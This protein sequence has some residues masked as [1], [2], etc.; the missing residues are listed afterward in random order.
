MLSQS[1]GCITC[2]K[3]LARPMLP[4]L[5]VGLW[6]SNSWMSSSTEPS[7]CHEVASFLQ[8]VAWEF[9]SVNISLSSIVNS[10]HVVSMGPTMFKIL[11]I[12]L[13]PQGPAQPRFMYQRLKRMLSHSHG[14][15]VDVMQSV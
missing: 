15:L 1:H 11:L 12:C 5:E 9:G 8:A 13:L 7:P 6:I 2:L 3:Q 14:N 4:S 10:A